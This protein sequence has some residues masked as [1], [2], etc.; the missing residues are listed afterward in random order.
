[1]KTLKQK[2]KSL[3]VCAL[4]ACGF[5]AVV[6]ADE[7]A[8]NWTFADGKLTEIDAEGTP[9]EGGWVFGAGGN[10]SSISLT[11]I[12]TTGTSTKLDFSNLALTSIGQYAC[13]GN[14]V[15]TDLKFP[16]CLTT[17][18][19][20]AFTGCS[21]LES[22]DFGTDSEL[23]FIGSEG[24]NDCKMLTTVTPLLPENLCS[25]W[26]MFKNCPLEGDLRLGYGAASDFAVASSTFDGHKFSSVDLGPKV[27]GLGHWVFQSSGNTT[28][29]RVTMSDDVTYLGQNV[30]NGCSALKTITPLVPKGLTSIDPSTY[31]SCGVEGTFEFGT[32]DNEISM[33]QGNYARY[34]KIDTI[35]FGANFTGVFSGHWQFGGVSTLKYIRVKGDN[36]FDFTGNCGTFDAK[37]AY[38][39]LVTVPGKSEN[40]QGVLA[41]STQVTPWKNVDQAAKDAFHANF[42]TEGDPD[43]LII[44]NWSTSGSWLG[45]GNTLI[46]QWI[47]SDSKA[48]FVQV[49]G[50]PL[51][52]GTP[53]PAYGVTQAADLTFP[54]T[55]SVDEYSGDATTLRR[56]T[57]HT[58]SYYEDGEWTTP[59]PGEGCSV[60]IANDEKSVRITWKFEEVAYKAAVVV[61]VAQGTVTETSTP[62]VMGY[63]NVGHSATFTASGAN[64]MRWYGDVAEN[65]ADNASISVVIDGPKTISPY[66]RNDWVLADDGKSVSDGYWTLGVSGAR[67]GL[68]VT[69]SMGSYY[70]LDMQKPI[71][72]GGAFVNISSE[73]VFYASPNLD[74]VLLPASLTS[75]GNYVFQ[76]CPN[77]TRVDFGGADSQLT[78]L[79]CNCFAGCTKLRTVTPLLPE[80]LGNAWGNFNGCPIEG[81]LRIGYG[82]AGDFILQSSMFNG[83]KFSS[84]DIGPRVTGFEH[85]VFESEGNT[86]L[87]KVTMTENVTS[88]GQGVFNGCSALAVIEPCLPTNTIPGTSAF[89]GCGITGTM[90]IG[91]GSKVV[92]FS[93]A[94]N[95]ARNT[96]ID[97]LVLGPNFNGVFGDGGNHW[98]FAGNSALKRIVTKSD[99]VFSF[100]CCGTFDGLHDYGTLVVI[101]AADTPNW[102]A[103]MADPEQVVRWSQL[104]AE[105]KAKWTEEFPG[106]PHPDG[107]IV[108]R[109]G[110]TSWT[111]NRDSLY[112]QWIMR[113]RKSGMKLI[114]K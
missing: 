79:G 30:F 105:V 99:N 108:A 18:N 72:D 21:N 95:F 17:I 31:A 50:D 45:T 77:L 110:N 84:V 112:N 1:M 86:T 66:F 92:S 68:A 73:K 53:S 98:T 52:A 13:K 82:A 41:D 59:V 104:D 111:T 70:V 55:C 44:S 7:W 33:N 83:H 2:I 12:R 19:H 37:G 23:T 22:V 3:A 6:Q 61:D 40:W 114:F 10:A 78:Y 90:K 9:V 15:F 35:V 100:P 103:V 5:A 88:F 54:L 94:G 75:L 85:Y 69:S 81:H 80:K 29:T 93:A 102:D 67:T 51:T 58:L 57:G 43:G 89:Y 46:N 62:D 16:A 39:I 47:A 106:E 24:F 107:L 60:V 91:F 4:V 113:E 48:T 56:C 65:Q 36:I 38:Q 28:L 109:W 97:T 71:A 25:T 8:S 76:N 49:V 14:K 32:G 64:F 34:T 20:W 42:P 27:T 63:Y 87:T 74:E 96:R 11:D 101:P 26:T